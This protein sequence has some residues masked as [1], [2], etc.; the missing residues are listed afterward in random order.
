MRIMLMKLPPSPSSSVR[1]LLSLLPTN[2]SLGPAS[3]RAQKCRSGSAGL[4]SFS[5]VRARDR[6]QVSPNLRDFL[7]TF[8]AD[9]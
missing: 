5:T 7:P 3:T 8:R 2:S 4:P 1:V 9:G 6:A